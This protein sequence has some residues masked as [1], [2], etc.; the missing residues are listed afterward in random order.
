MYFAYFFCSKCGKKV[1][2]DSG[3]CPECGAVFVD[4]QDKVTAKTFGNCRTCGTAIVH[5]GAKFCPKCGAAVDSSQATDTESADTPTAQRIYP[6]KL[7]ATDRTGANHFV[8]EPSKSSQGMKW[9]NFLAKVSLLVEAVFLYIEAML[10]FNARQGGYETVDS[11]SWLFGDPTDIDFY[12]DAIDSVTYVSSGDLVVFGF[13]KIAL[14]IFA[15]CVMASL[16][17]YHKSAVYLPSI[18]Y[19][20]K[21]FAEVYESPDGFGIVLMTVDVILAFANF[22]YFKNREELFK[23]P[24]ASARR[25]RRCGKILSSAETAFCAACVRE[26]DRGDVTAEIAQP[27]KYTLCCT[28]CHKSGINANAEF[29]PNCG[30]AFGTGK[31]K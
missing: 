14:A 6:D 13:I 22:A 15:V 10:C 29:C 12:L 26:I 27:P 1:F 23:S 30:A 17:S 19:A 5:A 4:S 8:Y 9:Y 11:L 18:F 31:E 21:A 3:V 16:L 28:S 25:C 24:T 20:C 7:R 2:D